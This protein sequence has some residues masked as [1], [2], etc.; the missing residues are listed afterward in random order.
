MK[1]ETF[2][3]WLQGELDKRNWSQNELA[4][5][6]G[7]TSGM[8]SRVLGGQRP[9]LEVCKAIAVTFDIDLMI[10][11]ELAGHIPSRP[12]RENSV[13]VRTLLSKLSQLP[14]SDHEEMLQIIN[15]KIER[16]KIE[17]ALDIKIHE[18]RHE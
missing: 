12:G 16:K 17:I 13:K 18:C 15:M 6:A 3:Q 2:V 8:I 14:E 5:E 10:V 7:L 1:S 11:L 9:G 4:H